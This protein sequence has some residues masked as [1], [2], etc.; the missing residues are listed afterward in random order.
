MRTRIAP[1]AGAAAPPA[2]SARTVFGDRRYLVVAAAGGLLSVY[3]QFIQV[4]LPVWIS[5]SPVRAVWL[6]SA[7]LCVN[8]AVV[9]AAQVPL[10]RRITTVAQASRATASAGAGIAASAVLVAVAGALAGPAVCAVVVAAALV[11][12]VAEA[13]QA[14]AAW[15]L[16]CAL[17]PEDRP[18]EY[19]TVF[20][21]AVTVGTVL[22]PWLITWSLTAAGNLGW[23]ILAAVVA[24]PAASH[25][26]FRNYT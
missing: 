3:L 20:T 8:T 24:A 18:M 19:Q 12:S 26:A 17:A 21:S 6:V 1:A 16:S 14:C 4:G 11:Y 2:E 15:E 25:L 13:V 10:A 23:L 7:A 9:A 5:Q 22:G